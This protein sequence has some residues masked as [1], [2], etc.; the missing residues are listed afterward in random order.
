MKTFKFNIQRFVETINGTAGHDN[1]SVTAAQQFINA[2]GGN[3]TIRNDAVRNESDVTISGGDGADSILSGAGGIHT[4]SNNVSIIGG[5]GNDWISLVGS[6]ATI[7]GDDGDDVVYVRN[8]SNSINGSSGDDYLVGNGNN[9]TILGET[10][11]DTVSVIGS[12]YAFIEGGDGKDS[13]VAGGIGYYGDNG[14]TGITINGGNSNDYLRSKGNTNGSMIGGNGDD[15]IV[16]LGSPQNLT[17]NGGAGNDVI[18]LESLA[19]ALVYFNSSDGND[20]IYGFDSN[21]TLQIAG[22]SYS[23]TSSSND[24]IVT[25][26]NGKITLV[27]ATG[28]SLNIQGTYGTDTPKV[29]PTPPT[30]PPT[31]NPTIPT[32]A[33]TYNG[34]SYYVYS[35]VAQTWEEAQEYCKARGGY[36]AVI[37]NSAEDAALFNYIQSKGHSNVYFGLSDGSAEGSWEWING[38]SSTYRNW[39]D[40]EPNGSTYENYGMFYSTYPDGKWNDGDFVGDVSNGTANFICEWDSVSSNNN[41]NNGNNAG[42]SSVKSYQFYSN[43]TETISAANSSVKSGYTPYEQVNFHTELKDLETK[44][45]NLIIYSNTGSLTI[46]NVRGQNMTYGDAD[47]NVIG[48]SYVSGKSETIDRRN[49]SKFNVVIGADNADNVIYAGSGGSN[50]WGGFGGKDTLIGGAG[51]DV[52][53]YKAGSGDDLVQDAGDNDLVNLNDVSMSQI[54]SAK[55]DYSEIS[56]TFTEGGS[57]KITGNSKVGFL[58]DGVTYYVSNRSTGDWSTK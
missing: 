56:V 27:G 30:I 16:A 5:A 41:D 24:V 13:L 31:V 1:I 29:D 26:G 12:A 58:V 34:H 54:V 50:M 52:F 18:D 15:T 42:G 7:S 33:L 17:I 44:G 2:L 25:A 8:N 35:N 43:V 21:D 10:G 49:Y 37:N 23:T 3:D 51:Y 9:I 57:L 55:V 14:G 32:D 22:S 39:A 38:D 45:D 36:L 48:Y 19:S 28:Y 47:G 53:N 40:G 20:T 4:P 6:N 46:A 11:N